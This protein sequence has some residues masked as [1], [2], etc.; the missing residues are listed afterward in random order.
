[1]SDRIQ[2]S[3]TL[4]VNELG[5]VVVTAGQGTGNVTANLPLG[6]YPIDTTTNGL[7]L[8]LPDTLINSPTIDNL[9]V[10]TQAEYD[11]IVTKDPLTLYVIQG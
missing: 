11:A 4:P 2:E 1:M 8:R 6:R 9:V 3:V 5:E 10:L 7:A